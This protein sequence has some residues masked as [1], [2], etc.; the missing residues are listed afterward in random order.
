M[1]RYRPA[2]HEKRARIGAGA[3]GIV[4]LCSAP[5]CVNDVHVY[6]ATR[7]QA[8]A[9]AAVVFCAL[10]RSDEDARIGECDE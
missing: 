10:H 9:R 3:V 8:R 1:S 4:R 5:G 2:A 7:S 6:C